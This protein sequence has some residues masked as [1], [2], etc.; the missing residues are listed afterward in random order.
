[1]SRDLSKPGSRAGEFRAGRKREV[2]EPLIYAPRRR[3]N[4]PDVRR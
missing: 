3:R 1:M 2:E 4:E